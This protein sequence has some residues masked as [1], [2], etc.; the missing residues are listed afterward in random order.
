MTMK[1]ENEFNRFGR[2]ATESKPAL[3][4]PAYSSMSGKRTETKMG[5]TMIEYKIFF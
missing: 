5:K 1:N 2:F 3:R 4:C